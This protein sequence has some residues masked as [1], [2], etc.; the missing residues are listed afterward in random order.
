MRVFFYT[1]ALPP[2][3]QSR[4][5]V[6]S[7]SKERKDKKRRRER[8]KDKKTTKKKKDRKRDKD[9]DREGSAKKGGSG[10]AANN[11]KM[12]GAVDQ[13]AFGK[14]GVLREADYFNKQREFEVSAFW[15]AVTTVGW[16]AVALWMAWT[17]RQD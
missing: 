8:S 9:K 11:P 10:G 4:R 15:S 3:P 1:V 12:M 5:S 6:S 16:C 14:Y 7:R 2:Y 17:G 13:N